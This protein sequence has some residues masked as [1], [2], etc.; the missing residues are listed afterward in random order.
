MAL[1]GHSTVPQRLKPPLNASKGG[2]T[3]E[4]HVTDTG[5]EQR[6]QIPRIYGQS[7]ISAGIPCTLECTRGTAR[8]TT[9]GTTRGAIPS[10][11]RVQSS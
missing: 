11:K 8:G 5:V 2:G 1:R 9:R 7:G 3:E 6:F 4:Q 10:L